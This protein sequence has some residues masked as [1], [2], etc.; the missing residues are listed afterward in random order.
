M[1]S[2]K[3]LRQAPIVASEASKASGPREAA[4]DGPTHYSKA[5]PAR[6]TVW[7]NADGDIARPQDALVLVTVVPRAA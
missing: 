7:C 1:E 6:V 3:R 2:G 4:L 5:A